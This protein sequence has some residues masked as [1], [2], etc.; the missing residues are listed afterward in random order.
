MFDDIQSAN[1]NITEAQE[2][3]EQAKNDLELADNADE[4]NDAN[5]SVIDALE[6]LIDSQDELIDLKDETTNTSLENL[7]KIIAIRNSIMTSRQLILSIYEETSDELPTVY[8][9]LCSILEHNNNIIQLYKKS[10]KVRKL[11]I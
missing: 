9:E 5:E 10:K 8:N 3:L 2:A 4:I 6:E 1:E 7:E 11:P